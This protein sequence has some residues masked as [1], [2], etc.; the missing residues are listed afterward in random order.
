MNEMLRMANVDSEFEQ[1]RYGDLVD[2]IVGRPPRSRLVMAKSR[3]G[4]TGP[5]GAAGAGAGG[6]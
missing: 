4:A 2:T 3:A 6:R 1:L 5:A